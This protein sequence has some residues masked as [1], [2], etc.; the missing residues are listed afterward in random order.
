MQN[1]T[2]QTHDGPQPGRALVPLFP[3]DGHRR[4]NAP[5]SFLAQLIDARLRPWR[6]RRRVGAEQ[7]AQR[8]GEVRKLATA[9]TGSRL[10][11]SV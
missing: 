7:A 5:A 10:E 2:P 11:R 3:G 1:G 4:E 9:T 6:V 8:Y